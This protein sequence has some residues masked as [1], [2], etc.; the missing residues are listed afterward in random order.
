MKAVQV[1]AFDGESCETY[2]VPVVILHSG[3]DLTEEE[4][5]AKAERN[6]TLLLQELEQL[7][8][9]A[10]TNPRSA[11]QIPYI[12]YQLGKSYYMA[13]DY[14]PAVARMQELG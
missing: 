4:R 9:E 12:I 8:C 5:K 13:G 2:Q 10:D 1:T 3:Y 11:E 7:K 6:S 14:A